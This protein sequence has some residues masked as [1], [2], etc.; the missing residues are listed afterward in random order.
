MPNSEA[1]TTAQAYL[2]GV[3][4]DLAEFGGVDV[5]RIDPLRRSKNFAIAVFDET[6]LLLARRYHAGELD[7]ETADW[8]A[9]VV[10]SEMLEL[11]IELQP[12][13][14]TID[15]PEN[16][17][18]VYDAFDAGEFDH[19]GRSQEPVKEFTDP[20]IAA[21]L[22]RLTRPSNLKRSYCATGT[23]LIVASVSSPQ[24]IMISRICE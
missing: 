10:E 16:W 4:S 24:V 2:D 1:I 3:Q 14:S 6:A 11:M 5:T 9:N 8:I 22:A 18:E 12:G 23:S 20:G 7:Y 13:Q 15:T 19:F 21:F 17:H